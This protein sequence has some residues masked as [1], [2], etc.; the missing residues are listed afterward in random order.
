MMILRLSK[1]LIL[2]MALAAAPFY[3]AHAE[4]EGSS[5]GMFF[6]DALS[7][8]GLLTPAQEDIK[9]RER[10]PLVLPPS[11]E[12]LRPPVDGEMKRAADPRWPNDP[13]VE[14]KRRA[15][16]EANTHFDQR[17][18]QENMGRPQLSLDEIRAGRL[19]GAELQQERR[20]AKERLLADPKMSPDEL[21]S[22][23]TQYKQENGRLFTQRERQWLTDPPSEYRRPAATA[24]N[25]VEVENPKPSFVERV[26]P[27]ANRG[28]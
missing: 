8:I 11:T 9:Y 21:R 7:T 25:A 27:F 12:T 19:K 28:R 26:N 3:G 14:A 22:Y 10:A 5:D 24:A 20:E 18:G 13:T 23:A 1:P 17:K 2:A 4:E 15:R 16:D 6:R